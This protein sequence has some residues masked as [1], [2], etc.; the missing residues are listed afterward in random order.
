[1][2]SAVSNREI[3][4]AV[5]DAYDQVTA[6]RWMAER[7]AADRDVS[8][9]RLEQA[10]MALQQVQAVPVPANVASHERNRIFE[11]MF[12]RPPISGGRKARVAVEPAVL[13]LRV[14]EPLMRQ[15]QVSRLRHLRVCAGLTQSDLADLVGV[16][17]HTVSM[18]EN[19]HYA[20]RP[21]AQ[22]R[23]AELYGVT[24]ADLGL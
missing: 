10:V 12:G 17:Q 22:R 2:S 7:L 6:W 13:A 4:R 5:D 11:E 18:W 16:R 9:Q 23:L 21:K 3:E 20:P 24:L 8:Q 14:G 19:G 1:M 15:S